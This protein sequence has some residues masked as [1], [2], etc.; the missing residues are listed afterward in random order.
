MEELLDLEP[1]YGDEMYELEWDPSIL[2]E[3]FFQRGSGD[4]NTASV[5]SRRLRDLGFRVNYI[6]PPT[7]HD[8]RA[9][10]IQLIGIICPEKA[11][12]LF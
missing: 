7:T 3:P 11:A 6:V 10:G 4:I 1:P 5:H 12:T 2:D 8:F 9:E